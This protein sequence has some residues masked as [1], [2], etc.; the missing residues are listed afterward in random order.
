METRLDPCYS[1]LLT[2]TADF[3]ARCLNGGREKERTFFDTETGGEAERIVSVLPSFSPSASAF[4][5]ESVSPVFG[6]LVTTVVHLPVAG[7]R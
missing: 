3:L 4:K 7:S 1:Y 6:T 2:L 5:L